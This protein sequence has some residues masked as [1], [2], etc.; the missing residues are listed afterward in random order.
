VCGINGIFAYRVSAPL[1][2]E[3][4]CLAVRDAMR[5]RGPDGAGLF[6]DGSGRCL[7]GHR[8]LAIIDLSD[9]GAQ[10]MTVDGLTISFN[11]EIYN[12]RELRAE[13]EA[14]G[15]RF[16][17]ATDTE[18]LLHLFRRDGPDLVRR[19]RGMFA[20]ALWDSKESRLFLARDP[21]GIKPLYYVDDGATF[22]FASSV[23]ALCSGGGFSRQVDPTAMLGFLG[24]GSVPE[25]LTMYRAVRALP[26]GSTLEVTAFGLDGP[27]RYWSVPEVYSKGS[28]ASELQPDSIRSS[29]LDSVRAHLVADVPVGVFL[30]SGI[31][32]SVLLALISEV[33]SEPIRAVT[34]AFAEFKG[35][36]QDEAPLAHEV[37][38]R[39]GAEHSVVELSAG[40]IRASMED[41]LSAMD[42]PTVDGLNIYWVSK[43]VRETGLKA[44]LS[45]L[46]GDELV[47]GYGSIRLY[48]R[49]RRLAVAHRIP[50]FAGGA[51]LLG[52]FAPGRRQNKLRS[53]G[54]ALASRAST[55]QLVRGLFTPE[56][57]Q[58]IVHPDIWETG[59]GV[60]G[61]MSP[62]DA[63]LKNVQLDAAREVTIAEQ[64]TYMRNQLLRDAD[65][66]S[67]KHSLEVRLPLVDRL[68]T[69]SLALAPP[70]PGSLGKMVLAQSV[71]EPLPDSVLRRPKT[72]FALPMQQW[73]ADDIRA[74]ELLSPSL[75]LL[76]PDGRSTLERLYSGVP[77]GRIHWSRP[78]ALHCLASW[79]QTTS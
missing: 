44:A 22:R 59:H 61:I 13:L 58:E 46:G 16:R 65:W 31:D 64:C 20:F 73:I 40:A 54:S 51:N 70:R 17:T 74:G 43:A 39:Y 5:E 41:F 69:E 47:G 26:A 1:P 35:T 15:V 6:R 72:G 25:P 50:G 66:A 12:Y 78:W 63:V 2:Q 76:R 56:E 23:R 24:W 62:V 28:P 38:L 33:H 42:Q 4:D 18:V 77:S 67:M 27:R 53:L 7:L 32:S 68:L 37:A 79:L 49:L 57:I 34:L 45:G 75:E 30:S 9:A 14:T 36:P 10:P 55:F 8:R 48:P 3:D 19:I 21:H 11:G 60:K 71:R 52:R 29:L